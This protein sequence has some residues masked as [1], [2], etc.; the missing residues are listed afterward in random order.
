M[1]ITLLKIGSI[2]RKRIRIEVYGMRKQTHVVHKPWGE[3]CKAC[4][5]RAAKLEGRNK[6]H[7]LDANHKMGMEAK[8]TRHCPS[9]YLPKW[10]NIQILTCL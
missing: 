8:G 3:T 4:W 10:Q 1:D 2:F 5:V 7:N 6:F 9:F